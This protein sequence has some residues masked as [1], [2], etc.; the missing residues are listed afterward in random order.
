MIARRTFLKLVSGCVSVAGCSADGGSAQPLDVGDVPAGNAASMSVGSL[1]VISAASACVGRDKSG[2]YAMTL[3]CTHQG[4][5]MSQRGLVTAQGI[6]CGCHGSQF[7]ADGNVVRGPAASALAHLSVSADSS[8]NL[9][10]HTGTEVA[11]ST[12]LAVA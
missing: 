12:R 9:T 6:V 5:D 4:C 8:G 3:I 7:D 1:I 10:I 2:I 11:S